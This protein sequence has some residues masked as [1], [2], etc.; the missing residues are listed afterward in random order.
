MNMDDLVSPGDGRESRRARDIP[1]ASTAELVDACADLLKPL[2]I[3]PW[4]VTQR[5]VRQYRSASLL[6]NELKDRSFSTADAQLPHDVEDGRWG[7]DVTQAPRD[8]A[9]ERPWFASDPSTASIVRTTSRPSWADER[10]ST[11]SRTARQKS[12]I[13]R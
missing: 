8:V 4:S 11:P 2:A 10:G 12:S 7:G 1:C 13:C 5:H 3:Y 9:T 6:P